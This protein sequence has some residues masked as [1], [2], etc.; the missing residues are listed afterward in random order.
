MWLNF[1]NLGKDNTSFATMVDS[2]W[3]QLENPQVQH[4][5]NYTQVFPNT[6]LC[7]LTAQKEGNKI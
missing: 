6:K 2:G 1:I 5:M 4:L 3:I 7:F